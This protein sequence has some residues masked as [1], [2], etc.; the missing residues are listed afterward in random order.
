M[1]LLFL[2]FFDCFV[3]LSKILFNYSVPLFEVP[4][5]IFL[6]LPLILKILLVPIFSSTSRMKNFGDSAST[7]VKSRF[8]KKGG[9]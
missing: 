5:Y 4:L 1:E 6:V 9:E 2:P 7:Y 8:S 3:E